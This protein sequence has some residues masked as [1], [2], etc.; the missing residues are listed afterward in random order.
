MK[1]FTLARAF[2]LSTAILFGSVA[3]AQILP[4][5]NWGA[6]PD[7][8]FGG[9]G[10]PNHAVMS[11]KLDTASVT[12]G[13]TAHQ[14]LVGP[15]LANDGAGTFYANTGTPFGPT[16]PTYAGWNFGFD[17]EGVNVERFDYRLYFDF[18]PAGGNLQSTHGMISLGGAWP[19]YQNSWNLGM[20]F[21]ANPV[22]W[23]GNPPPVSFDANAE[24]QY[25][26]ALAA[27]N[28]QTN[29]EVG[30][31]A[32]RV[33]TVVPEPSTY[34]LMSAGLLGIFGVARRRRNA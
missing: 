19:T 30:R 7:M 8:T 1:S 14:R 10:I 18:N 33:N 28:R 5:G 20:G 22:F 6:R 3:Q 11:F 16:N 9:T 4:Q 2:A 17:V 34:L 31:V 29:N 32:I 27:F 13:L 21:L 24:G 23:G 12:L 15:N 25:T 26:F